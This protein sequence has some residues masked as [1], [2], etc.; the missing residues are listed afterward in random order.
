MVGTELARCVEIGDRRLMRARLVATSFRLLTWCCVVLLAVLSLVPAQEMVR[1]GLPSQLEHLAAYAGAA[2]IAVAGYGPS[3]SGIRI[4][5]CFWV[6]AGVLECL[7]HFSP[8]RHPSIEDFAVSALGALCGGLTVLLVR[9]CLS[10]A[11]HP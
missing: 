9:R 3:Q 8:G 4:I 7:Q 5:C 11:A 10:V 2:A 1:T 6:Y